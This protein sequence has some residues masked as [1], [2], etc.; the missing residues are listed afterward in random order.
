MRPG[1]RLTRDVEA[2]VSTRGVG[3]HENFKAAG[4]LVLS[5]G[6]NRGCFPGA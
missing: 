4:L 6:M 3:Q 1:L 5:P 2:R